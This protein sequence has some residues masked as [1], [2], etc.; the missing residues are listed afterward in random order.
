MSVEILFPR[1][2]RRGLIEARSR[3]ETTNV[4]PTF[5]RRS[6][7]GLIEANYVR[8]TEFR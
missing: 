4:A 1:R 6:R 7:R 8:Q 2:S 5:P 3:I